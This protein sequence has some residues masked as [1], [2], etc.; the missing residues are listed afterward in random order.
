M[1]DAKTH[2]QWQQ[3]IDANSYAVDAAMT[4]C[5]GLSLPGSGWR[6]PTKAELESIIKDDAYNPAIDVDAFPS[7]PAAAFWTASPHAG[8]AASFW[9]VDFGAGSSEAGDYQG[10]MHVRCVR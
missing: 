6:L 10:A 1:T 7:T 8:S 9:F 5:S 3:A 2:L 4:Y